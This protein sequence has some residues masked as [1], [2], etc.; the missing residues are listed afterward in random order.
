MGNLRKD[1]VFGAGA[2]ALT[3]GA[4]GGAL[5]MLV[6]GPVGLAV[7]AAAGGALGALAGDRAAEASEVPGDIAHAVGPREDLGRFHQVFHTMPYYVSGMTWD[8]YAPAYRYGIATYAEGSGHTFLAAEP[9]LEMGW[10]AARDDSRLL[11]SEAREAVAHVWRW[12]DEASHRTE[13]VP[14]PA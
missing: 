13:H 8:D 10:E 14:P 3:G 1:H 4:A 9:A 12:Y 2:A 6:G 11:W 7:G 5:G